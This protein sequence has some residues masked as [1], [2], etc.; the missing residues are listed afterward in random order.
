MNSDDT[1]DDDELASLSAV[2]AL[3]EDENTPELA[4]DRRIAVSLLLTGREPQMV[5]GVAPHRTAAWARRWRRRHPRRVEP[6]AA[7]PLVDAFR[8][9]HPG[10]RDELEWLQNSYRVAAYLHGGQMRKSGAPYIT[11]PLA[12]ATILAEIGMDATTLVAAL[13]HDTVEDTDY[14]L[15]ECRADFG[16]E[17]ALLVDGVTKLDGERLG[18]EVAER[19]TFAKMVLAAG[20]DLRVLLIKLVDRL[21][22]LRTLGA[23][24][25]HKQARIARQSMDLL[26]PFCDRLGLYRL[27]CEMEDLAFRYL[28]PAQYEAAMSAVLAGEAQRA[29]YFADVTAR[30]AAAVRGQ[31][32][33]ATA[34]ARPRHLYS[35]YQANPDGVGELTA[36]RVCRVVV[37][38]EGT[39]RDCWIA[40]GAVHQEFAP[41]P[42]RLRDYLAAPKFNLYRSLHTSVIGPD[43]EQIDVLIRTPAMQE[44]AEDGIAATIREISRTAGHAAAGEPAQHRGDLEWLQQLLSWQ[45]HTPSGEYL[46]DLRAAL[47]GGSIVVVAAP[48]GE[49]ITLPHGATGVDYAFARGDHVGTLVSLRVNGRFAAATAPLRNGDLVE[50]ITTSEY[51]DVPPEWLTAARTPHARRQLRAILELQ[52][53]GDVDGITPSCGN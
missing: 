33:R 7:A 13:L 53:G 44:V 32:L 21:H 36:G 15:G 9:Q 10:A 29:C 6:A 16:S 45:G 42:H 37:V 43:G 26:V 19:K 3:E 51:D 12:V 25:P 8:R 17:V 23:Q 50:A 27:K 30:M 49:F 48:T 52:N 1:T 22:N 11:H 38:V 5:S 34:I 46:D 40:L 14:T 24:P 39:E 41:I 20:A 31:G 4:V 28:H 35:L 18:K 2:L 47:R